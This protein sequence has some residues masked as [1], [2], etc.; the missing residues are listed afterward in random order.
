MPDT[1]IAI[2]INDSTLRALTVAEET[3][4]EQ[5]G[6][7]SALIRKIAID[8]LHNKQDNSKRASLVRIEAMLNEYAE[9]AGAM[10]DFLKAMADKG[11]TPA[12]IIDL[13]LCTAE[14]VAE[15]Y[16]MHMPGK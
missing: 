15:L 4:P 5:A 6:N 1:K 9:Q 11:M 7:R 10:G 12:D 13:L 3:W 2:V 8:W 16:E 14:Q